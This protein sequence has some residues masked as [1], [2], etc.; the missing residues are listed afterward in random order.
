MTMT[1][2][3]I[4]ALLTV[5]A[6]SLLSLAGVLTVSIQKEKLNRIIH[7]LVSFAVGTLFG[8]VFIH[9][10]PTLFEHTESKA[11]SLLVFVPVGI[12]LFFIL[13]K[14][15]R[16][17]HCHDLDCEEHPQHIVPLNLVGD[18]LHNLIDGVIIGTAFLAGPEVGIAT[19][20][21]VAFHELP[22]EIGDFGVLIHGGLSIK[23]ALM[24]NFIS[25]LT[26]LAGAVFALFFGGVVDNFVP[27][28]LPVT[29]G[30]F[31]YIAGS[32]LI[33]ELHHQD[34]PWKSLGQLFFM[35]SGLAVMYGLHVI[36]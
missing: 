34:D 19:A 11:T 6:V 32:D 35:V 13:E 1:T 26:A 27:I 22:Q 8:G 36:F 5:L 23:K 7:Y 10:L 29:A 14:F 33:P 17:R 4:Y 2:T 3:W 31:I 28:L 24:F 16:W 12:I 21:A 9:L 20:V 25:S 30:G 15:V 18:A